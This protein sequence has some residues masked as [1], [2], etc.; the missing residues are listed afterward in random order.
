[1]K[2][3]FEIVYVISILSIVLSVLLVLPLALIIKNK[4]LH[5]EA[6]SLPKGSVRSLLAI[7]ISA[8][9]LCVVAIGPLFINE[10]YFSIVVSSLSTILGTALGFYFGTKNQSES[11]PDIEP[12]MSFD[13]CKCQGDKDKNKDNGV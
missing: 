10:E 9:F 11:L 7:S 13:K 8:V 4:E 12:D 2:S 6:L 3:E 5:K 1:M